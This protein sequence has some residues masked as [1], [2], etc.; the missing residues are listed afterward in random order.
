MLLISNIQENING[1]TNY[2]IHNTYVSNPEE[3]YYLLVSLNI[4][5]NG[6]FK[7][8]IVVSTEDNV[9]HYKKSN[10]IQVI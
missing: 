5:K 8:P 7:K 10:D 1:L 6:P 9:L 3:T 4:L 2:F